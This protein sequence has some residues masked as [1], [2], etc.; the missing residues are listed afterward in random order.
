MLISW[1]MIRRKSKNLDTRWAALLTTIEWASVGKATS[2]SNNGVPTSKSRA[3]RKK[4]N[5]CAR[6][7]TLTIPRIIRAIFMRRSCVMMKSYRHQLRANYLRR[8]LPIVFIKLGWVLVMHHHKKVVMGTQKSIKF[9]KLKNL[10]MIHR[11]KWKILPNLWS[12]KFLVQKV[13]TISP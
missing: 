13:I 2:T 12:P 9:S 5:P 8:E 6:I 10:N 3:S 7:R 4:M 11:V 1:T